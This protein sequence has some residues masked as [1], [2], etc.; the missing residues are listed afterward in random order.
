MSDNATDTTRP[1]ATGHDATNATVVLN[2]ADAAAAFGISQGA[3][4]KRL[5]RGQLSGQKVAGQWRV[6]LT[7]ADATNATG[8]TRQQR[9]HATTRDT[10]DATNATRPDATAVV[11][12]AARAQLE[13]IRDEFITPL[14]NRIEE[15]SRETGRLAEAERQAIMRTAAL[16]QE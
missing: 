11:S 2:V 8:T 6:V 15:L 3:V 12:N 14:V 13:A 5:E 4:R 10:T 7:P 9:S 1:D 16:E